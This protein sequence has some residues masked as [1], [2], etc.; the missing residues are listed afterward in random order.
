MSK[1]VLFIHHVS[2]MAGAERYLL[3]LV[4]ALNKTYKVFFIC[5]E[6][7]PLADQLIKCGVVVEYMSLG[8]WRKFPLLVANLRTIKKVVNF[9]KKN[10]IDLICSN[11]YRVASYGIWPARIL[12]IPSITIIQDFVPRYKLWK[13]N[14]FQSN[15]LI[16][17]SQSITDSVCKYFPKKIVSIYNGLDIPSFTKNLKSSDVLRER[18]YLL[19]GKRV[20]GMVAHI[21]PLKGHKFFLQVMQKI[22]KRFDDVM[23]V[24]IGDSPNSRQL[25]LENIKDYAASLGLVDRVI[26]TG[27]QD[28]V[29]DLI[30][31]FD[32]LVHPSFK[33]AFG[34]VI[35]EAM[36]LGVPVVATDCGGPKEIIEDGKS[37]YLVPIK[38]EEQLVKKVEMLLMDDH[39]RR[40]MGLEGKKRIE[41]HFS[42]VRTVGQINQ[43]FEEVLTSRH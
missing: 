15:M 21:I 41:E 27:A 28:D 7:G 3:S 16:T 14:T 24:M 23:F 32:I 6:P 31:S 1:N 8:A 42:I 18:F 40:A 33:E 11:N 25:S 22:S 30:K 37:G 13:F 19:K 4:E 17:V 29:P 12:R 38:D 5:Q 35:M 26:F 20:V 2:C 39:Q 10:H 36:A 9:C 43:V 34:R